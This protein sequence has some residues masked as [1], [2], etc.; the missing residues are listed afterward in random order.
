MS[1]NQ[2]MVCVKNSE[3]HQHASSHSFMTMCHSNDKNDNMEVLEPNHVGASLPS[4]GRSSSPVEIATEKK[5][6]WWT[7][8][9][10]FRHGVGVCLPGVRS[11]KFKSLAG[12]GAS[13]GSGVM[14]FLEGERDIQVPLSP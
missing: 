1:L 7:C 2:L 6:D 9:R 3:Q 12:E 11:V 4:M 13:F 8:P 10:T 14:E 5:E